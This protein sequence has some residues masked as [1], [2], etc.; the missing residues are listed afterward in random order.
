MVYSNKLVY[1]TSRKD[2]FWVNERKTG[3][4]VAIVEI[5][6]AM[7]DLTC[8]KISLCWFIAENDLSIMIALPKRTHNYVLTWKYH[9]NL[10]SNMNIVSLNVNL[11][12][13]SE[14]N[15]FFRDDITLQT[16]CCTFLGATNVWLL[17]LNFQFTVFFSLSCKVYYFFSTFGVFLIQ[18]NKLFE[19]FNA[20]VDTSN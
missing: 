20:F 8:F 17:H 11:V 10:K 1:K 19:Y 7:P 12:S 5:V 14:T 3:H 13:F 2:I 16:E 4:K 6:T 9:M 15:T 18:F